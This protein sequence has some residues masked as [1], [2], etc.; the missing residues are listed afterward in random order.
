[1]SEPAYASG[2]F[3][4]QHLELRD[5]TGG[6]AIPDDRI[7][8]NG[9]DVGLNG[10]DR[11]SGTAQFRGDEY[12]KPD[13]TPIPLNEADE[14]CPVAYYN[15]PR[16]HYA[17]TYDVQFEIPEGYVGRMYPR[18]RFMRSGLDLTSALWDQ[19]YEGVGEGLLKVPMGVAVQLG[20]TVTL[21]QFTLIEATSADE[22]YDGIHQR[23]RLEA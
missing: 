8:P 1:M 10:L 4:A 22:G 15:L 21:G 11:I 7:Q 12:D 14:R 17:V 13:R 19:G 3:V 9:V 23:E 6:G 20:C 5:D 16:G 2:D 18:S